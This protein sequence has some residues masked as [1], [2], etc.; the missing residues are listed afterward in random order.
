VGSLSTVGVVSAEEARVL[1]VAD[2]M[3]LGRLY[4]SP[5]LIEEAR[6]RDDLRV[7]AEPEP[8][9]FDDGDFVTPSPDVTG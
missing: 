4:A 1:R 7:V 9:E 6:E 3:H 5:A 2:T 8:V